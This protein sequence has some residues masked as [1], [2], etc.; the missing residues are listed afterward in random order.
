MS[1]LKLW[2]LVT[3]ILLFGV[4]MIAEGVE[5]YIYHRSIVVKGESGSLKLANIK[6]P[7]GEP[8]SFYDKGT[9]YPV[10]LTLTTNSGRDVY[11]QKDL[12]QWR[13]DALQRD[14]FLTVK[15]SLDRP[16]YPRFIDDEIDS[17][18]NRFLI[19]LVT[20]VITMI[21]IIRS[22]HN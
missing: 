3:C 18:I 5:N 8:F 6:K 4:I 12:E 17:G 20:L 1:K 19:G 13:L 21:F 10:S 14:G 9:R 7:I 2:M 22:R 11:I 16:Q 15:Y